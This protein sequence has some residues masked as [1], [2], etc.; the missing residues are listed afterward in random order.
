MKSIFSLFFTAFS[1][2]LCAQTSHIL[3]QGSDYQNDVF[4]SLEN[5]VVSEVPGT[6]W[7]L[8]F[9]VTNP[10]SAS[11]RINDG[12]GRA[13]VVYPNGASMTVIDANGSRK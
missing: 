10:F 5:G 11:I 6:N 1:S 12:H 9:D 4:F 13:A 3:T 8:A 2:L 7:D